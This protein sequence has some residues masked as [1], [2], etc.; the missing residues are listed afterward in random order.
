[1]VISVNQLNLYGAVADLIEELPGDQR[2]SGNLDALD[3]MEQKI[4]TQ[5]LVAE[6]QANDERQRNQLQDNERSFAKLPE[7][8]KLTKLCSE[9][10]MNLLEVGQIFYALPSPNESKTQ[11]LCR[12]YSLPQD[13]KE[14]CAEGW[15]E[16][17]ARFGLVLD[18]KS[19]QNTRNIQR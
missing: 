5:P 18:I 11:C 6:V 9:A 19:L 13:E 8:Q 7:H 14:D 2:A 16:S 15:I 10:G 3:Q 12:E 1:M 4:L 17:D